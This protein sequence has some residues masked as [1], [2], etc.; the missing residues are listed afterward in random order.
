MHVFKQSE[1]A[2]EFYFCNCWYNICMMPSRTHICCSFP[3][4]HWLM[5]VVMWTGKMEKYGAME[6]VTSLNKSSDNVK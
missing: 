4:R 1:Y 3:V 2:E 5:L 6:I